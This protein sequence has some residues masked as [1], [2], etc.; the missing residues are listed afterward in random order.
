MYLKIHKIEIRVNKKLMDPKGVSMVG[1]E[2]S[3]KSF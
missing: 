2:A 1:S 3:E